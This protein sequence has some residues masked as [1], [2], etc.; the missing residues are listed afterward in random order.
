MLAAAPVVHVLDQTWRIHQVSHTSSGTADAGSVRGRPFGVGTITIHSD[1][2]T[3]RFT[4][5]LRHGT[6]KGIVRVR[7]VAIGPSRVRYRGHGR[8]T[9]GTRAYRGMTGTIRR[10]SGSNRGRRATLHLTGSARY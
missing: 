9:G 8:F 10:F 6:V 1:G 3:L 5:R 7:Y 2:R 4:Q